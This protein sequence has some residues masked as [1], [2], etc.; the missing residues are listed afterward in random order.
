MRI[1]ILTHRVS[2]ID[3]YLDLSNVKK[4]KLM[5]LTLSFRSRQ[6]AEPKDRHA[7]WEDSTQTSVVD[8]PQHFVAK[9]VHRVVEE[10]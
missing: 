1:L 6:L 8:P 7:R 4:G 5:F 9:S 3:V 10:R 2:L